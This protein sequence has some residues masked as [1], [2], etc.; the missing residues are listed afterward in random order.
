MFLYVL[1]F[2]VYLLLFALN[3]LVVCVSLVLLCTSAC[4]TRFAPCGIIKISLSLRTGDPY[5]SDCSYAGTSQTRTSMTA[6]PSIQEGSFFIFCQPR[7]DHAGR[8]CHWP[9]IHQRPHC[10]L[11]QLVGKLKQEVEEMLKLGV[12]KPSNSE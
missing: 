1:L 5:Y 4:C 12:I 9:P 10:V 2:F 7:K 3:L 6:P 8:A 11:Q